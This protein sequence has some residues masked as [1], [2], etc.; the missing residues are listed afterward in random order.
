VA[1]GIA[2]GFDTA[3]TALLVA[4]LVVSSL[5]PYVRASYEA[6]FRRPLPP[7]RVPIGGRD[8][9]LLAIALSAVA[10][11]PL[12]GL[13]AT[14]VLGTVEL[15]ARLVASRRGLLTSVDS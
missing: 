9:R 3:A 8:V 11:Q 7:S 12:A 15:A 14:V 1:L 10:L 4:A 6:T 13:A 5:V 2:A